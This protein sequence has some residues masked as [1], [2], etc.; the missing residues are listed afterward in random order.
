MTPPSQPEEVVTSL[1][2]TDRSPV[3]GVAIVAGVAYLAVVDAPGA[4]RLDDPLKKLELAGSQDDAAALRDLG[5]RFRQELRRL[6]PRAVAVVQPKPRQQ[7]WPYTQAF[8][9]TSIEVVIMVVLADEGIPYAPAKPTETLRAL[10]I[11]DDGTGE[12]LAE[13]LGGKDMYWRQ[14][15]LAFA[16]AL[17]EMERTDRA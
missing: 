10:K 4:A 15:W 11:P 16:A 3:L 2:A 6:G 5:E 9:R 13:R 1:A 14:R 8:A 17:V 7:G 12:A